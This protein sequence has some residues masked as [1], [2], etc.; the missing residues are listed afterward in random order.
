MIDTL[1]QWQMSIWFC[2]TQESED[3]HQHN[4]ISLHLVIWASTCPIFKSLP[5]I[6]W[7]VKWP[8]LTYTIKIA[9]DKDYIYSNV[10]FVVI[11]EDCTFRVGWIVKTLFTRKIYSSWKG[12]IYYYQKAYGVSINVTIGRQAYPAFNC[13]RKGVFDTWKE[14]LVRMGTRLDIEKEIKWFLVC[15]TT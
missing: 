4:I 15:I 1:L 5:R 9:K 6:W 3:C 7:S 11:N 8:R 12:V 10:K 14:K 2:R 13:Y